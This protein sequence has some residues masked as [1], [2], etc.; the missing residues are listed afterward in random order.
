[1]N[2]HQRSAPS[3][4]DQRGYAMI[5]TSLLLVPLLGFAG[6][7]VDVGSWYVRASGLQ[8]AADS[9]ALAGVVWQP[10]FAKASSVA[11]AAAARNGFVD[12]VDGVVVSVTDSGS[13][14]LQVTITDTSA[15]LFF[16]KLFLNNV[17]ISRKAVAEYAL[18]VPL[19]SP[20]NYIGTNELISGSD[21]EGFSSA[22]NGSCN[23][24]A[25]GGRA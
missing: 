16:S 19:G 8:K 7:A 13:A 1:M 20:K 18:A 24:H 5:L 10:D 15:D 17:E 14:E 3:N 25:N 4:S 21:N 12:G 22:I 6:F 23:I 9:A 2:R 11:V